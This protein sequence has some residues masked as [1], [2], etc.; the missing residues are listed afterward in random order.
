MNSRKGATMANA[1]RAACGMLVFLGLATA[2]GSALAATK[3]LSADEI[4]ACIAK[5]HINVNGTENKS[6]RQPAPGSCKIQVRNGHRYPDPKCTPGSLN[7]S[8]KVQTLK[9]PGFST[10][11]IRNQ[12]TGSNETQKSI[13]FKWYGV[14]SDST[15]EKDHFV[16]LEMGGADTLDNIWPQCGPSGATG[17]NRYFRQKDTVEG[18][19]ARQV[20]GGMSQQAAEQGVKSDW[21]QYLGSSN[22]PRAGRPAPR[23][24]RPRRASRS[25]KPNRRNHER[26]P[27]M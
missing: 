2:A 22:K 14:P 26:A 19:L 12:A 8:V 11:C 4:A 7:P 1:A 17:T 25:Q 6:W 20:K 13:V 21:T 5:F 10:Q 24:A 9:S 16:P 3:R 23:R 27:T 15:C 18:Y